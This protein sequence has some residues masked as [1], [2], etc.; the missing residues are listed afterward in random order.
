MR[1]PDGSAAEAMSRLSLAGGSHSRRTS[2]SSM[3]SGSPLGVSPL[4][5]TLNRMPS[6]DVLQLA[7]KQLP[8]QTGV[9]DKLRQHSA[10]RMMPSGSQAGPQA[11]QMQGPGGDEGLA[12]EPPRTSSTSHAGSPSESL[13][14]AE[15]WPVHRSMLGRP[16]VG[17]QP[18]GQGDPMPGVGGDAR[19]AATASADQVAMPSQ[20]TMAQFGWG[21]PGESRLSPLLR[22]A[23][24]NSAQQQQL[25]PGGSGG[26]RP[27]LLPGRRQSLLSTQ[28]SGHSQH[29]QAAQYTRRGSKLV[30][31]SGV[32]GGSDAPQLPCP[33]PSSEQQQASA[34][35]LPAQCP[36]PGPASAIHQ[37]H[38]VVKRLRQHEVRKAQ[39]FTVPQSSNDAHL[40]RIMAANSS[41]RASLESA[42]PLGGSDTPSPRGSSCSSP[43]R[44]HGGSFL[45]S[46]QDS[47]DLLAS[48]AANHVVPP[49]WAPGQSR[50]RGGIEDGS[51]SA[52]S[53][54]P[55]PPLRLLLSSSQASHTTSSNGQTSSPLAADTGLIVSGKPAEASRWS[56]LPRDD[57]VRSAGN[58]QSNVSSSA[59][60]HPPNIPRQ[61]SLSGIHHHLSGVS[62]TASCA[63]PRQSEGHNPSGSS[64]PRQLSNMSLVST[65]SD[66]GTMG[67]EHH[68][69]DVGSELLYNLTGER[70]GRHTAYDISYTSMLGRM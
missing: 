6:N 65:C 31:T 50:S 55:S 8:Q 14:T 45:H 18:I 11:S 51:G 7:P 2:H 27:G 67:W 22:D 69:S 54:Q 47:G 52:I 35:A 61:S 9:G 60:C 38:K 70:E 39:S 1:L 68:E 44:I 3:A 5:R 34:A 37:L 57:A 53:L 24:G 23:L 16:Y 30:Q 66:G 42:S 17:P 63:G 49:D 32:N 48:S 33:P 62:V 26:S 25:Y 28:A 13:L 10:S 12:A 19:N 46:R 36:P 40:A 58:F 41:R 43:V 59:G 20:E 29:L 21:S 15:A 56:T 4:V 64:L